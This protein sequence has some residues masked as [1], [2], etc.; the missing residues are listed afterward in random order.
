M[1]DILDRVRPFLAT[2]YVRHGLD[3]D[4]WDCLGLL[5]WGRREWFGLRTPFAADDWTAE[6]GRD[7]AAAEARILARLGEWRE[8][9][10]RPGA[11]ILF[12]KLGHACHVGLLLTGRDFIHADVGCGTATGDIRG[13]WRRRVRGFYDC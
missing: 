12:E 4:G 6:D 11:A 10:P 1:S 7:P 8:V 9:A 5:R 2:P 13:K 3:P